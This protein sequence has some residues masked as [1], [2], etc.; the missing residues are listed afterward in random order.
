MTYPP[1]SRPAVLL[2]GHGTRLPAGVAEFRALVEAGGVPSPE[3][4][5]PVGFFAEHAQ[6]CGANVQSNACA[7]NSTAHNST[8]L[9]AIPLPPIQR[10]LFQSPRPQ[11]HK[12]VQQPPFRTQI[13]SLPSTLELM[14]V[15]EG[16]F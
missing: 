4:L 14:S 6:A 5:D 16:A 10:N 2:I 11:I 9:P 1:S 7:F 12:S 3:V 8:D 15:P 13:I